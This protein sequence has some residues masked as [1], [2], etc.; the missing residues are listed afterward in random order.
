MNCVA[1]VG[2]DGCDLWLGTQAANQVQEAVA[3]RLRLAP[4]R[5][6]V[7]PQL[8]GGGFG[9]RL[10]LEYPLEAVEVASRVKAPVQVLWT[11]ADDMRYGYYQPGSAHRM[12]GALDAA[13]RVVG[14]THTMAGV[15]HSAFGP[16]GEQGAE[17]ARDLMW[18]GFDNPYR[19]AAMRVAH[20]LL[21][22]PVP[23]GPWRAVHYPPGL[24]ARECFIDELAHAGGRDP[25]E[26]RLA[27][28]TGGAP[29]G[30]RERLAR[31]VRL[32]AEKSGWGRPLSPGRGRG[33]AANVYHGETTMAQIVE[34]AV[35]P[36]GAVRVERIVCAVECGT[37]VNPLGLEGQIESAIA[38]GLTAALKS[39]IEFENGIATASSYADYPILGMAEMPKV[40]VHVIPNAG[41]PLGIGEQPVAPVAAAVHNAI[42][43]ATGKRVRRSPVRAQDLI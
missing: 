1:R 39:E 6:R 29:G 25:V 41:P 12:T 27:L 8:C 37:V 40:Q 20:T 34:V 38:W 3:K 18:G 11:R 42:F 22:A 33:I 43:A 36:G 10:G 14:W 35:G 4:E 28:L 31:A 5:V 32:A 17:L 19:I 15:P 23:T 2:E 13:G 26:L 24:L 16:P 7:H 9:R 21:P 30:A